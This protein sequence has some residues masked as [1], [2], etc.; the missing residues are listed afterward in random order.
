MHTCNNLI[1]MFYPL[2]DVCV[3]DNRMSFTIIFPHQYHV[4]R[5]S[6]FELLFTKSFSDISLGSVTTCQGM[7]FIA[8]S[9]LPADP[10]FNTKC[11]RVYEHDKNDQMIFETKFDEHILNMRLTPE[12]LVCAFHKHVEAWNII[13][14]QKINVFPAGVNVHAPIDISHDFSAL[15]MSGEVPEDVAISHLQNLKLKNFHAADNP[16]SLIR[17]SRTESLFATTSSAGHAIKIWDQN[18]GNCVNK[19]KRGN[20]ASIIHSIDFSPDNNF[21]ALFSQNDT[22]HFFDNSKRKMTGN[23]STTRSIHRISIPDM[24]NV[25]L[26][27]FEQDKIAV[28]SLDGKMVVLTIDEQCHEIAR[29]S[30]QFMQRIIEIVPQDST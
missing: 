30:I 12:F 23:P 19:F 8:V 13:E 11:V 7:R 15:A 27:W 22:L 4:F 28:L 25:V 16:V 2:R 18:T 14:K 1:K 26:S 6:P 24:Q 3:N 29:E 17:F 5:C 21:V 20:T 10:V 9:G